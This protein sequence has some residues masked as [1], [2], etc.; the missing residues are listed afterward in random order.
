MTALAKDRDTPRIEGQYDDLP[1]KGA[2]LIYAG[3]LVCADANGRAV[4][5]SASAAL[6]ARGRAECR[7]DN[8]AGADGD[9]T[10]R[11][12]KGVYR[13][14][15]SAAG[16][17]IA[18]TDVGGIAFVV[19]DQTVAKTIG[20]G[21]R[22]IAGEIEAIDAS[23]VWVRVGET[24]QRPRVARLLFAINETDT[25]AG[26]S[27]ELISPVVGAISQLRVIVQKAVTTGGPVSVNVG[28]TPVAGLSC[29]IADAAAKG[30]IVS[31]TP[32]SGDA[33]CAVAAGQRIQVVP[34]AAFA[35]AGAI[36]G[37][38]EITY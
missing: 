5:G 13:F 33:T 32:T 17:A 11:V 10:V 12:R 23:G 31:D 35:G 22:S 37:F 8:S 25:L 2:T 20:A 1:V 3:S 6:T 9:I 16:D 18:A 19:D 34:D 27:A 24:L 21:N 28:A 26:T 7:A 30:T 15:N 29:V 38:V 4:P 14:A 36:S